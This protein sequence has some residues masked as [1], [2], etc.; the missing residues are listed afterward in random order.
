VVTLSIVGVGTETVLW[1][2]LS[3]LGEF[4]IPFS[5]ADSSRFS[6]YFPL[7]PPPLPVSQTSGKGKKRRGSR[8]EI[9]PN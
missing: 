3:R 6:G 1:V 8:P 9:L 7:L 4:S 5:G 2:Q